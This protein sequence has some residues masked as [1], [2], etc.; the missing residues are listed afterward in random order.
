MV[1]MDNG[2]PHQQNVRALPSAVVVLRDASTWR[3]YLR[4]LIP[5]LLEVLAMLNPKSIVWIP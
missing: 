5:E 4:Q 3:D 1:I 2:V